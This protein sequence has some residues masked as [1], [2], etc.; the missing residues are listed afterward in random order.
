MYDSRSL[1]E[2]V[3]VYCRMATSGWVVGLP[4]P[5]KH[6]LL[7]ENVLRAEVCRWSVQLDRVRLPASLRMWS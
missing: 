2:C 4:N 3:C 1:A 7:E 5:R 6:G